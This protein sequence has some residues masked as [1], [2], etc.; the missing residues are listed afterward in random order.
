MILTFMLFSKDLL[1]GFLTTDSKSKFSF[2]YSK[3][4]GI[5]TYEYY[6]TNTAKNREQKKFTTGSTRE[7]FTWKIAIVMQIS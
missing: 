5:F 4:S 7:Y 3:L 6:F 2:L 1:V